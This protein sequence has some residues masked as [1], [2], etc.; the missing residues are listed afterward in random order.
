MTQ[1]PNDRAT[2]GTLAIVGGVLSLLAM[3]GW[4]IG[5]ALAI[6]GGAIALGQGR[7]RDTIPPTH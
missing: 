4:L 5:A 1:D 2:A 3:G 6:I 7:T